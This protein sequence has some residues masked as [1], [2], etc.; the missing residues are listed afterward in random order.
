MKEFILSFFAPILHDEGFKK[1]A[2]DWLE[3]QDEYPWDT[4]SMKIVDNLI[5]G[6]K[7]ASPS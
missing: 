1:E 6:A 2:T 3:R 5:I 7:K 4:S